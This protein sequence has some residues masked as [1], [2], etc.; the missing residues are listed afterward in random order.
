MRIAR[1]PWTVQ[2]FA[3]IAWYVGY[4]S[5]DRDN[6]ATLRVVLAAAIAL[7][8]VSCFAFVGAHWYEN[9]TRAELGR[10]R[11]LRHQLSSQ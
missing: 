4:Y 7:T 6:P 9:D 1:W 5:I 10:W 3:V 8:I 2:N 11:R